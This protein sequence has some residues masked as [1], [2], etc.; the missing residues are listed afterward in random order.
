MSSGDIIAIFAIVVPILAA[1]I[2]G[3][4][5]KISVLEAKLETKNEIITELK[6][7]NDRLE[8]TGTL[9]NRFFSQLP[10]SNEIKKEIQP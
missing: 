7:Q 10:S 4:I 8:I 2:A 3:L 9:V 6:R 5:R 1:I